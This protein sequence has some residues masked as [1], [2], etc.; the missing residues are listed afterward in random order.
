MSRE[1][2]ILR[3]KLAATDEAQWSSKELKQLIRDLLR[4]TGL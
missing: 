1:E 3:A 2:I 4:V